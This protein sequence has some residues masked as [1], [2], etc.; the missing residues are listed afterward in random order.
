[1]TVKQSHK[2]VAIYGGLGLGLAVLAILIRKQLSS[3]ASG[4]TAA[5]VNGNYYGATP[6]VIEPDATNYDQEYETLLTNIGN[7][8]DTN[9]N[10]Q[11]S[12]QSWVTGQ[13]SAS[14]TS[15]G[16]STP[17]PAQ[18]PNPIDVGTVTGPITGQPTSGQNGIFTPQSDIGINLTTGL[19]DPNNADF[20]NSPSWLAGGIAEV[21]FGPQAYGMEST[22]PITAL[23]PGS[24]KG[25]SYV[26]G[27]GAQTQG[28][29]LLAAA[30]AQGGISHDTF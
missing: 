18:N 5:Q 25:G 14:G 22:V 8:A 19:P 9:A 6:E 3:G 7:L 2:K 21:P 30:I 10:L 13:Q 1:M 17:P 4:S 26:P 27:A 12:F 28:P 29:A 15:G 20:I 24:A 16:V 23:G 11:E